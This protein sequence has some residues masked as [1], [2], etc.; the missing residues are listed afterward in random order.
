MQQATMERERSEFQV[1]AMGEAQ[2][3][4][5]LAL[6]KIE[7]QVP[8]EDAAI[9]AM[10]ERAARDPAVDMDKMKDLWAM[11]REMIEQ[12]AKMAYTAAFA[13]MQP[14][15]PC[16][17]EHGQITNK[18]GEVQSTYAEW[19]DIND[20]VKPIIAKYG[21]ALSFNIQT[22]AAQVTVVGILRHIGGHSDTAEIVL[23]PDMT[24]SKNAVQGIGSSISYG[25]RYT[26]K[27]LLNITSRAPQDRDNDGR[28]AAPTSVGL[29][30]AAI[31][32]CTTDDDLRAWKAKNEAMLQNLP[33]PEADLI[34]RAFNA[35]RRKLR[36]EA[37]A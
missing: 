32:L 17:D 7:A 19:E 34:V 8:A 12:R 29:A 9:L 13:A 28:G 3:S 14:E 25:Q 33:T 2:P 26:A 16:I 30:T 20:A 15:I 24:G 5:A 10:I 1:Q 27:A 37:Q 18:N 21:F 23:A 31:D 22:A 6:A 4:P 11:R 36:A 35:R